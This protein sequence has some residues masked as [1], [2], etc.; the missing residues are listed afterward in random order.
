MGCSLLEL[1]FEAI[2]E[3]GREARSGDTEIAL[4]GCVFRAAVCS[5]PTVSRLHTSRKVLKHRH[6]VRSKQGKT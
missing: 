5:R 4:K 6:S 1:L 2:Q 3:I